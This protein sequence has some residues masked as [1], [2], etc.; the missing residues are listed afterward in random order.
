MSMST[1]HV[2][3]Q[4]LHEEFTRLRINGF[5]GRTL[6]ERSTGIGD[7]GHSAYGTRRHG[8]ECHRGA[9]D[10]SVD[11]LVEFEQWRSSLDSFIFLLP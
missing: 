7:D 11:L 5:G 3:M 4:L 2:R 10:L 6:E 1:A 9:V 8:L